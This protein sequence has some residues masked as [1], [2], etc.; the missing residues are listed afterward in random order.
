MVIEMTHLA[1]WDAMPH[2][3]FGTYLW[4]DFL[5]LNIILS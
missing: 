1:T 5:D 2:S 3:L 4:A